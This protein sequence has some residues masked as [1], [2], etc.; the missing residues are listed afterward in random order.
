MAEFAK[1]WNNLMKHEGGF[2]HHPNDPGGATNKG[3]ILANWQRWGSDK[4]MDG[5]IDVNDLKLMTDQ[6]AFDIYRINF[7]NKIMA[8]KIVSQPVAEIIFD[9]YV[10]AP[11]IAIKMLQHLLNVLNPDKTKLKVDGGMG[12][13]TIAAI[14]FTPAATLHDAYREARKTYYTYRANMLDS[15]NK[16]YSFF[17]SIGAKPSNAAQAFIKGW[18]A[19]VEAF[20][21][22][23]K[24]SVAGGAA[25]IVA[26]IALYLYIQAKK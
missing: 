25:L 1:Y 15:S 13:K 19:R 12:Y 9:M 22:L 18:L 7:W 11:S 17:Q 4:D 26:G 10:N 24:K 5:D 23:K 6:E 20:P 3:I 21:E 16:W 14:N 2:V 8:D